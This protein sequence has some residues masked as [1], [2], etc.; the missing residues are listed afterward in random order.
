M[1]FTA[2][3]D[4]SSLESNLGGVYSDGNGR[5]YRLVKAGA[6][7]TGAASLTL[8]DAIVAGA[9][10][11]EVDVTTTADDYSVA[12]VVPADIDAADI[13]LGEYFFV[14]C[15][16]AATAISAGAVAAGALVATS[17]TAG[18]ID[19]LAATAGVGGMGVALSAAGAADL[20]FGVLI[21]G[22]L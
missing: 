20:P 17:T 7:I 22:L 16:G 6:A 8:V 14:Q 11:F 15:G 3:S 1:S 5:S 10:T 9:P 13:A 21:K 4:D 2:V 19:D 12:G 18:K